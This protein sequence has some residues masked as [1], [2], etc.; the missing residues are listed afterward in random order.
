MKI[1]PKL[2]AVLLVITL[3]FGVS[4]SVYAN[5]NVSTKAT[6]AFVTNYTQLE[7]ALVNHIGTIIIMN[8]ITFNDTLTIDYNVTFAAYSNVTLFQESNLTRHF[9]INEN[10]I[11]VTFQGVT[12]DGYGTA[13]GIYSSAS[14]TN[15]EG[16]VIQ[17]CRDFFGGAIEAAGWLGMKD[18]IIKN[19]N[20]IHYGGGV[21][22]LQLNAE[23]CEFTDNFSYNGG[24][25]YIA[26]AGSIN[27]CT[28]TN[29]TAYT[30][31]GKGGAIYFVA[32]NPNVR[33]MLVLS[34]CIITGNKAA[35]GGGI[36]SNQLT[37]LFD[38]YIA[39]NSASI[40]GGGLF[41]GMNAGYSSNNTSIYNNT[42]NNVVSVSN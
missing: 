7:S 39:F 41:M 27:N 2:L 20:V 38:S 1:F 24:G 26:H 22:C 21:Y 25:V 3:C 36:Y 9:T 10:N 5:E 18:C 19:N 8:D 23:N 42:P 32:D 37:Y 28:F 33:P 34:G 6:V 40:N 14:S 13:G 12:L 11:S 16:A 15:I 4:T 29:N 17:N 31:Y 35:Y 30:L